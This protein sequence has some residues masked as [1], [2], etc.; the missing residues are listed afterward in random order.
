MRKQ[1]AAAWQLDSTEPAA[2]VI[3]DRG[4]DTEIALFC[5]ICCAMT[6]FV[7]CEMV[8]G[9]CGNSKVA[10]QECSFALL[11]VTVINK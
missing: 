11:F 2:P 7:G 3:A 9:G 5:H 10:K 8:E 4:R 1:R 6:E